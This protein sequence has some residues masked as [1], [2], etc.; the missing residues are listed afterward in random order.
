MWATLALTGS[1]LWKE[2]QQDWMLEK[3]NG[4]GSGGVSWGLVRYGPD[5]PRETPTDGR[6]STSSKQYLGGVKLGLSGWGLAVLFSTDNKVR[7]FL[8]ELIHII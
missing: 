5:L 3:D 4:P 6:R 2:Q 1:S 7:N 8:S